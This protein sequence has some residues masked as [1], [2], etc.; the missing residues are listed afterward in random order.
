MPKCRIAVCH[1]QECP[2]RIN[3]WGITKYWT[4]DAYVW[5][6]PTRFSRSRSPSF[7]ADCRMSRGVK[8]FDRACSFRCRRS[9]MGELPVDRRPLRA[10]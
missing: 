4:G 1:A 10:S 5:D 6:V 2:E 8:T 9:Y 3:E 7:I